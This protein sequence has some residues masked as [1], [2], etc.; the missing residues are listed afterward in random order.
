MNTVPGTVSFCFSIIV[1]FALKSCPIFSAHSLCF[2]N[3]TSCAFIF[4][5]VSNGGKFLKSIL[6]L[7]RGSKNS[8][9]TPVL[10]VNCGYMWVTS[11]EFKRGGRGDGRTVFTLLGVALQHYWS[12]SAFGSCRARPATCVFSKGFMYGPFKM[13]LIRWTVLELHQ[14]PGN[15]DS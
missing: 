15:T 13:K 8:T 6:H 10:K 4:F 9:T 7:S 5:H 2:C 1:V 3:L 14:N 12:R 11:V